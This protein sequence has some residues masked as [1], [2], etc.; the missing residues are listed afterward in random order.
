MI[1]LHG[2]IGMTWDSAER[3]EAPFKAA[4]TLGNITATFR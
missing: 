4:N 1:Q 2:A 3:V